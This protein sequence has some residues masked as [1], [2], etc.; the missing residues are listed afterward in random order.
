MYLQFVDLYDSYSFQASFNDI[1]SLNLGKEATHVIWFS[2]LL[3][4]FEK[5]KTNL[6][7]LTNFFLV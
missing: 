6:I 4:W 1:V 2:Q 3:F 7:F 5:L